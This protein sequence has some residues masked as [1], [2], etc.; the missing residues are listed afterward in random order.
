MRPLTPEE[1]RVVL[2]IADALPPEQG[3]RVKTDLEGSEIEEDA[4]G[5]R[6]LFSISGYSRP[7]YRGQHPFPVEGRMQDGDGADLQ[8]ILHADEADRLLE[9]E[10]IRWSGGPLIGPKWGSFTVEG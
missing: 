2:T 5:G 7:P 8:V 6:L 3:C 10:I 9:L 4:G 1:R